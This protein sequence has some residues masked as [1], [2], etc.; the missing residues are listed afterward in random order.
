MAMHGYLL[1]ARPPVCT[2]TGGQ[3]G[4]GGWQNIYMKWTRQ[5]IRNAFDKDTYA[6]GLKS[7]E[8]GRVSDLKI[9]HVD[10]DTIVKCTVEDPRPYDVTIQESGPRIRASCT[11]PM[12]AGSPGPC[13]HIVAGMLK[14]ADTNPVPAQVQS[15]KGQ[16]W[17]PPPRKTDINGAS[18]L[19]EYRRLASEERPVSGTKGVLVPFLRPEDKGYPEISFRVGN[20]GGTLY[21]IKN[22]PDFLERVVGSKTYKYGK[23]LTLDHN[24]NTF[25]DKSQA[26]IRILME[27]YP[28]YRSSDYEP[29][30]YGYGYGSYYNRYSYGSQ[31]NKSFATLSGAAFDQFFDLVREEPVNLYGSTRN[32]ITLEDGAP[33]VDLSVLKRDQG[34]DISIDVAGDW[35]F[36]G[37]MDRLYAFGR[38][39]L[40]RCPAD[41]QQRVYPLIKKQARNVYIS[42]TD[43]P[44]FCGY[45]LPAIQNSVQIKDPDTVLE[46]FSPEEGTALFYFDIEGDVLNM[47]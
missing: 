10:G 44:T 13:K 5:E 26:L 25:D 6:R 22:I 17:V 28:E 40:L 4:G 27:Q 39:K 36:F 8:Q 14:Y 2:I 15:T 19:E 21:V 18:L 45:V 33:K 38:E 23:N 41:Y 20:K 16:A 29:P 32:L 24:I 7:Y 11:C 9:N 37:N 47:H 42:S 31:G 12:F 35:K 3:E 1:M 43:L 30:R 46:Q 34:A